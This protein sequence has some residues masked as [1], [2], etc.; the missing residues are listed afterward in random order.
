M[1]HRVAHKNSHIG[2]V[3]SVTERWEYRN[4]RGNMEDRYKWGSSTLGLVAACIALGAEYHSADKSE[5]RRMIFYLTV[6]EDKAAL[7]KYFGNVKFDFETVE[8]E[9]TNGTLQVNA[10]RYF[11]ALADL[12]SVIH[13]K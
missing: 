4:K 3:E 8:R 2:T 11:Q 7:E 13:S 1:P 12:K 5:S 10:K 6:P 9:W